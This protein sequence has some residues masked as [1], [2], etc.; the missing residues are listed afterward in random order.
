[1]LLVLHRFKLLQVNIGA[2]RYPD[3]EVSVSQSLFPTEES[4]LK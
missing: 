2:L 1:M 3:Y 4:F